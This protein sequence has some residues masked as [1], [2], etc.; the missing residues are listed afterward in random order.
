M[1]DHPSAFNLNTIANWQLKTDES[2]VELPPLQRSFVWKVNQVESLWDSL[3][4]GY[5][6][7]SFLLSKSEDDQMFLMDGQQRA[8]S[9]ALGLYNPWQN[10]ENNFWSVKNLPTVWIDLQPTQETSQHKFVIRVLTPSHPWGYQRVRHTD[11]LSVPDKR[12]ALEV[13]KELEGDL[14]QSYLTIPDAHKFPFD[15]DL[16]VPL[17]FVIQAIQD[18]GASWKESLADLCI[19]YLPKAIKTKHCDPGSLGYGEYVRAVILD[20]N[21]DDRGLMQSVQGLSQ[22]AIPGIIIGQQSLKTTDDAEGEDPTLFVRLNAAGTRIVGEELIYSIY[23]ASFPQAKDLV[24]SIGASFIAPSQVIS[25]ASRLVLSEINLG[26]YPTVLVVNEFIKRISN[27]EFRTTLKI[28]IGNK[29]ISPARQL[30]ENGFNLILSAGKF[31]MPPV[32]VKKI[33][34]DSPDLFLMLLHWLKMHPEDISNDTQ[35]RIICALT[36]FSWFG[37]NNIK[38][39][40]ANWLNIVNGD[41]WSKNILGEAFVQNREA[42]MYPL[43]KP[44]TLRSY[45]T[46]KISENLARYDGLTPTADHPIMEIY[47]QIFADV[48]FDSEVDQ[49]NSATAI[50]SNFLWKLYQCKPLILFAQRDYINSKFK[51]YNQMETLEDTNAPWDWDH[52]YP[53]S[54]IYMQHRVNAS[55]RH[56]NNSIGNLRAMALEENRSESNNLPPSIRLNGLEKQSF[57]NPNDL[58]LWNQL[59]HRIYDGETAAIEVH[60]SAVINRL[61]NIYEHWY[62]TLNV[63]EL[64]SYE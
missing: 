26:Q 10:A 60:L 42:I 6:I 49:L 11:P 8:T 52:I 1:I 28:F 34:K 43:L 59:D 33:I 24:E 64:F 62:T 37:R 39:V 55:M 47:K 57:V 30:F 5:P 56:W 12:R 7:G 40:R 50:W 35:Q 27:P 45:L 20:E 21:F 14:F 48:D 41:F 32:L 63:A 44:Q 38:Y 19:T 2:R 22:I 61:C 31:N 54:W 36:A 16:P 29:N 13:L 53:S 15:A 51:D 17:S 18:K 9:I 4:R 23:K 25:L 58:P 46:G 3:L